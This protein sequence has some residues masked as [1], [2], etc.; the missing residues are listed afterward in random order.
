MSEKRAKDDRKENERRQK[1]NGRT[2]R[3][4]DAR[5]D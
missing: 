4:Y 1:E 2:E 3:K 5:G